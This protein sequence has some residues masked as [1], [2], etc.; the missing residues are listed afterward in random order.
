MKGY[1]LA[2][3]ISS[4]IAIIKTRKQKTVE[5]KVHGDFKIKILKKC[6]K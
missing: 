4:I 3:L 5:E 6:I 1:E 2:R